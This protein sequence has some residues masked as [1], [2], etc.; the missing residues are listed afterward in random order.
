ML[1]QR[2]IGLLSGKQGE[3]VDMKN[4]KLKW[5]GRA[6]RQRKKFGMRLGAKPAAVH[7]QFYRC[8]KVQGHQETD[9]RLGTLV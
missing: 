7:C 2:N 3:L 8:D 5:L 9:C 4:A 1:E 6:A